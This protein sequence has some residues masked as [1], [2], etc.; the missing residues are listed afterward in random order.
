MAASACQGLSTDMNPGFCFEQ[1]AFL[2]AALKW[3]GSARV[4]AD[5]NWHLYAFWVRIRLRHKSPAY[6]A[7]N[8]IAALFLTPSLACPSQNNARAT[9]QSVHL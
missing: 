8:L 5:S 9:M 2:D 1:K 3:E 4:L 6:R 7:L